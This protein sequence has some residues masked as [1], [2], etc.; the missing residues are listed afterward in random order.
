MSSPSVL[1][2]TNTAE[3]FLSHRLALAEFLRARGWRVAII[4]DDSEAA[5]VLAERGYEIHRTGFSRRTRGLLGEFGNLVTIAR[6]IR[7]TRPDI[8]HNVALKAVLFGSLAGRATSR[9]RIVNA[10]T[11]LGISFALNPDAVRLR[12]ILLIQVLRF[13]IR[14]RRC[15]T[16]VQNPDDLQYLTDK[17]MIRPENAHLIYGSGADPDQYVPRPNAERSDSPSVV[18]AARLLWLSLIHI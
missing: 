4:T 13:A 5:D 17:R 15:Y 16:I 3:F 7:R 6:I 9:A 14:S 12:R 1:F 2:L 8:I 10:I 11:G 18:L